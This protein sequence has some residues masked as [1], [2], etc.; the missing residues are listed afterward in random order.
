MAEGAMGNRV[1]E[2][3]EAAGLSQTQL[4]ARIGI[5]RQSLG[6]IEA[7]RAVPAVDIALSLGRVLGASVEALFGTPPPETMTVEPANPTLGRVV[8]AHL[9]GRWV[10]HP[11]PPD[12]LRLSADG[13]ATAPTQ[14]EPT[15]ALANTRENIILMGCAA[16]LGILADRLNAQKGQGRF[17][18]L[19]ASS[20]AALQALS[21]NHIHVA[22]VHLVDAATGSANVVDA[23]RLAQK[24][25]LHLI[26]LVQW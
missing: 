5:A 2:H 24:T 4:A 25:A 11:A 22:G 7:G 8:L 26:I 13:W 6:A 14:V 3:R 15:R 10:A 18:W 16:G 21:K 20:T 19:S 12:D 9:G 1:R 17:L 23:Q